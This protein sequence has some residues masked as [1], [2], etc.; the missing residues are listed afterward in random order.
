VEWDLFCSCQHRFPVLCVQ[1][2]AQAGQFGIAHPLSEY[3][4]EL[5]SA[6]PFSQFKSITVP[7]FYIP[8]SLAFY[9]HKENAILP[10]IVKEN[11]SF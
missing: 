10:V 7:Q 6:P 1:R 9:L 4:A 3:V 2:E 8:L 5:R 11:K